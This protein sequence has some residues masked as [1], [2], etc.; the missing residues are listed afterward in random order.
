MDNGKSV[1]MAC[2]TASAKDY[3]LKTYLSAYKAMEYENKSLFIVDNTADGGDYFETILEAGENL[4]HFDAVHIEPRGD[5]YD[6]IDWSWQYILERGRGFDY[7]FSLEADIIGPPKTIQT[8][9][10]IAERNN[11]CMVRHAYPFR[12]GQGY[13]CSLGCIL[14]ED[15]LIEAI[16]DDTDKR[17][18]REMV[19]I[20][21]EER[22][23]MHRALESGKPV[24]DVYNYLDMEHMVDAD[25]YAEKLFRHGFNIQL[26]G[27]GLDN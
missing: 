8:L 20:M 4:P 27:I 18:D 23:F 1:L 5:L 21:H 10:D 9:V 15:G 3:S 17:M 6:T 11:A 14:M 19:G 22:R 13:L 16:W 7:I 12:G 26:D 24:M 25:T 2:P